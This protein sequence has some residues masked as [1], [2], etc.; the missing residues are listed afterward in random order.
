M[1]DYYCTYEAEM[2]A[3][4]VRGSLVDRTYTGEMDVRAANLD[5]AKAAVRAKV[6][7]THPADRVIAVECQPF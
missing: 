6:A 7:E 4:A 2:P 3:E 5:D 1:R